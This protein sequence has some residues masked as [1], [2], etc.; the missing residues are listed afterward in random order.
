MCDSRPFL[1]GTIANSHV[2]ARTSAAIPLSQSAMYV[3]CSLIPACQAGHD[4][5]T[6]LLIV[7]TALLGITN[8]RRKWLRAL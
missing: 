5:G 6:Q 7:D 1:H 3:D 2:P 4:H 8:A